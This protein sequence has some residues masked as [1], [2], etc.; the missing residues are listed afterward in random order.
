MKTKIQGLDQMLAVLTPTVDRLQKYR[1]F[2]ITAAVTA[3]I[4]VR[5]AA[6]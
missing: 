3:K 4:D 2:L 6:V 1:T 5:Q